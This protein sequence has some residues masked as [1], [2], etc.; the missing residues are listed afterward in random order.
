MIQF[1]IFVYIGRCRHN[2]ASQ[3]SQWN[4]CWDPDTSWVLVWSKLVGIIF[5]D[6]SQRSLFW[7]LP[8]L[9]GRRDFSSKQQTLDV[10][11]HKQR[12]FPWNGNRIDSEKHANVHRQFWSC[13]FQYH[14]WRSL[15]VRKFQKQIFVFSFPP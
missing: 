9:L 2:D 3:P 4:T 7:P 10:R 1:S 8:F 6:R 5:Q 12:R 15:K 13:P 11:F 14:P